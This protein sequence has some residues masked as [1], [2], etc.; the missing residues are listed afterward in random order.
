V[1]PAE[2][3]TETLEPGTPVVKVIPPRLVEPYLSG[4]RSVI[5]GYVYRAQDCSCRTPADYY[6]SLALG[7]EGSEFTADMPELYVMRW[8]ALDMSGSVAAVPPGSSR[9]PASSIPEFFTLPVPIPVGTEIGRVTVG[10]EEFI[11]RY[12]GQ[13]WLRPL[14]EG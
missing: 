4:Q 7:Y 10:P 14:R 11:A 3:L 2:L 6:Q 9:G 5:A 12:D 13:V 8:I 1:I